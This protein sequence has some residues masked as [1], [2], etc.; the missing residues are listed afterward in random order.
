MC[1]AY[2]IDRPL[3]PNGRHNGAMERPPHSEAHWESAVE[4]Q[5]REAMA[6]GDFDNLPGKGKPLPG[7]D[8]RRD[9]DWWIKEKLQREKL[10]YLPP[11]LALRKEV[12]DSLAA[13]ATAT[14]EADVRSKVAAINAR[15]REVNSRMI[16]GP[17]SS[18]MPLDVGSVVA[19]WRAATSA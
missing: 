9:D 18:Q 11:A 17:P 16:E 6:R 1:I 2:P 13:I 3:S 8:G 14:S 4:K 10:S 15:I 7:L 19:R 5:I 12:E